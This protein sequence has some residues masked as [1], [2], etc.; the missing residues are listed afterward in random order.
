MKAPKQL[1]RTKEDSKVY[2]TERK[3]V[4]RRRA[5]LDRIVMQEMHKAMPMS[6]I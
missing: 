6:K 5:L 1:P 4:A 3:A 2:K